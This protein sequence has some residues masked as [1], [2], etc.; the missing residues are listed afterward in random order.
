MTI[1]TV[2]SRSYCFTKYNNLSIPIVDFK[3]KSQP[4]RY[5]VYQHELCPITNKEHLQGYVE[6]K[7]LMTFKQ[8]K[9][10]FND[11][12]IH[13]EKR[14]G[15]RDQARLYCMKIKTRKQGTTPAEQGNWKSG[16]QGARTDLHEIT[17]KILSGNLNKEQLM[18]QYPRRYLQ[19]YK[20][21]QH[22]FS[23][24]QKRQF[25]IYLNKVYKDIK[26]KT[27]QKKA[28]IRLD[29]QRDR[30]ILWIY[31]QEGNK[32]KTYLAKYLNYKY[33][34]L[35]IQNGKCA[36]IAHIYDNQSHIVFDFTRSQEDHI[37][38]GIIESFKNGMLFSPKY[39][40]Q[41]KRFKPCKIIIMANFMSNEDDKMTNDRWDIYDL[42]K[43]ITL[44]EHFDDYNKDL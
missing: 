12:T 26:L 18:E 1:Q 2:Q 23:L 8:T 17:D 44:M 4:I 38:Y 20:P 32:G 34:A 27:W 22:Y 40:S 16:G 31:D 41:T 25:D 9:N 37:N 5:V 28:L 43:P 30:K 21:F 24:Y 33:G 42:S 14:R 29:K 13:L 36:D 11:Q 7:K 15:T 10:I 19:Y 6:F 35:Y 3:D 39:N